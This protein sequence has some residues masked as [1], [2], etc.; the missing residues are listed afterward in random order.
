MDGADG[1]LHGQGPA[2]YDYLAHQFC[3]CDA[4][5]ASVPGDTW[6]NRLFALAGREGD[7]VHLSAIESLSHLLPGPM[8]ALENAPIYDVEAFTRHLDDNQWRWA[9]TTPA[10][11]RAADGH[12]RDFHHIRRDNFAYFDRKK[13]SLPTEAAEALIVAHDS[14]LDDAANGRTPGR[15]VD[16]PPTS[17]TSASSTPTQTTTTRPRT[18]APARRSCSKSTKRFPAAPPGTTRCS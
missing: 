16:R 9:P 6:P 11:L 8:K 2:H 3:V 7:K 14:F 18:S 4:W 17:S 10:T 5:H 13:I 12:Y 1:L 15:L